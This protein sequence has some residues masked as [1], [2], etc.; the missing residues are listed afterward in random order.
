VSQRLVIVS[1][2]LMSYYTHTACEVVQRAGS[3]DAPGSFKGDVM[4]NQENVP[5][6]TLFYANLN[7]FP[8]RLPLKPISPVKAP[9]EVFGERVRGRVMQLGSNAST[10]QG[11]CSLELQDALE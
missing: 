1:N 7:S 10:G 8:D 4:F 3:G 5:S 11:L 2:G 6:E 9:E